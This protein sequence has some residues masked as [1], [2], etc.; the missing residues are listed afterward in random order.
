MYLRYRRPG[1]G[2]QDIAKLHDPDA[3]QA[4]PGKQWFKMLYLHVQLRACLQSGFIQ[5]CAISARCPARHFISVRA[6]RF[7]IVCVRFLRGLE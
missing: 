7:C 5:I 1:P 6:V 2:S 3:D 4:R